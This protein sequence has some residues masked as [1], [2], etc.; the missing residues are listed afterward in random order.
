MKREYHMGLKPHYSE[1]ADH[2]GGKESHRPRSRGVLR[3][4]GAC[5]KIGL[6][7]QDVTEEKLQH[8]RN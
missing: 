7:V 4:Y 3:L 6:T 1:W 2:K 8:I 5:N